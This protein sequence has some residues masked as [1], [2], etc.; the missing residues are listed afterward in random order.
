MTHDPGVCICVLAI[1]AT[2]F[3]D[4]VVT[5]CADCGVVIQHRPHVPSVLDKI[6]IRCGD[7]R[8]FAAFA[9][10]EPVKFAVTDE[11][12][13]EVRDHFKKRAH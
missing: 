6:C 3:S 1:S 9:R 7:G 8:I 5:A 10:G 12:R 13:R 2:P 11:T 4:N